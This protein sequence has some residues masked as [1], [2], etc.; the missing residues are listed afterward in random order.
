MDSYS[1]LGSDL[2]ALIYHLYSKHGPLNG[3]YEL[4]L[5]TSASYVDDDRALEPVTLS[6]L[7]QTSWYR[8][9][10]AQYTAICKQLKEQYKDRIS[11][12]TSV[13][14]SMYPD[15]CS[16]SDYSIAVED[17]LSLLSFTIPASAVS[18]FLEINCD[19]R[20]KSDPCKV[21]AEELL[22]DT[23]ELMQKSLIPPF[24]WR[25]AYFDSKGKT[26]NST[27]PHSSVKIRPTRVGLLCQPPT[28]IIEYASSRFTIP[29]NGNEKSLRCR[30][31]HL[32]DMI[33]ESHFPIATT[34]RRLAA[35][36]GS[37]LT[38]SSFQ[39]LLLQIQKM[40]NQE[41][42][43]TKIERETRKNSL[44]SNDDDASPPQ[45]HLLDVHGGFPSSSSDLP[46][47]EK[48]SKSENDISWQEK[49]RDTPQEAD[50]CLL[51]RDPEA[52]LTNVNLNQ[53]DDETLKEYKEVMDIK[54]KEKVLKPGDV[55]YIYDKR[56]EVNPTAKSEWDDDSD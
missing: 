21:S 34:A 14:T 20:E 2:W 19:I 46:D 1:D 44:G 28:I 50:L 9:T 56:V 41:L 30:R 10:V 39:N 29:R 4:C 40:M 51:Y 18:R 45:Q 55:G 32:P 52:A 15:G 38:E 5:R 23:V 11:E 27:A 47:K 33:R 48:T 54:F 53:A 37:F 31:I 49:Y 25:T 3:F 42:D 22:S 36:H 35:S 24:W 13:V 17:C 12:L 8:D 7:K 16:L 6:K 26:S 43:D